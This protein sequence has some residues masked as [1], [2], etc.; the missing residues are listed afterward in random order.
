MKLYS[1][2][3]SNCSKFSDKCTALLYA[4]YNEF[5]P[6]WLVE[7][8]SQTSL[9]IVLQNLKEIM[10]NRVTHHK[11]ALYVHTHTHTHTFTQFF[12]HCHYTTIWGAVIK[13]NYATK[14][15]SSVVHYQMHTAVG[16]TQMYAHVHTDTHSHTCTWHAHVHNA[17][18]VTYL[19]YMHNF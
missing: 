11:Y 7:F 18:H 1:D 2:W 10:P 13:S 15:P 12:L 4:L 16:S 6:A 9:Y 17:V 3:I 14:D 8:C 19:Q 5:S